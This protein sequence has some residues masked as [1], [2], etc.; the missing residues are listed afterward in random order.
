[1]IPIIVGRH[2]RGMP[3]P[4]SLVRSSGD[5]FFPLAS[6]AHALVSGSAVNS[7]RS[8]L[9]VSSLFYNQVLVEAGQMSIQAGPHGASAWR[10]G[11]DPESEAKW[12]TP[13]GRRRAQEVP[14][15]LSM[16]EE[17]EYGVPA[18]GPYRQV[19]ASQTSIDWR[20]TL[21]PFLKELPPDCDWVSFGRPNPMLPESKK[22]AQNWKRFD[23]RNGA[24]NRLVPE[25]F[26]RSRLVDDISSDLAV[27]ASSGWDVSVD[28]FH[29]RVISAR[30]EGDAA[31]NIH[32]VAL[33]ILVPRVGHLAW[34]D[35]AAIRRMKAMERLREVLREVEMEAFEV[36]NVGGDLEQ[37]VRRA[38]DRK[39]RDAAGNVESFRSAFGHSFV[40]FV[41]GA[42]AGYATFGLAMEA[43]LVG[44]AAGT[45]LM[46]GIQVRKDVRARRER[47][48]IGVM[49]RT[50]DTA[51]S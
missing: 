16:A 38:Y 7:V 4:V 20:P 15:S 12:Q 47:G 2:N 21:E 17:T 28:R 51:P 3:E 23:Q 37:A 30:F 43:P 1:M 11:H 25:N 5:V 40:D 41:V 34:D 29:G 46:G 42:V 6:N 44:A 27:G 24:L 10:H 22:L 13:S 18:P 26:V 35:V 31:V 32:G 36:A 9:K 49:G 45:T 14:F 48:W 8:R 50:S 39:L 19:L 33:P